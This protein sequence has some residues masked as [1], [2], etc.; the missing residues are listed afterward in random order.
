LPRAVIISCRGRAGGRYMCG[1]WRGHEL[2][3]CQAPKAV[4]G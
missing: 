1:T 4:R 3:L 2:R